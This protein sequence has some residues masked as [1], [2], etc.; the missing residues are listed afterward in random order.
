MK[1]TSLNKLLSF[2]RV[3][4]TMLNTNKIFLLLILMFFTSNITIGQENQ[5][6]RYNKGYSSE[7]VE[8]FSSFQK[9]LL[10]REKILWTRH[11]EVIKKSLSESQK[12]IIKDSSLS[13][14][15][16]RQKIILSLD[17]TQKKILKKFEQRIDTIR[18]KFKKSLTEN[19]KKMIRKKKRKSKKND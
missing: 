18:L 10:K 2:I 17:D 3:K 19:Q 12:K 5:K 1:Y 15:D 9:D 4:Q 7:L 6:I 13:R 14:R 11:H 16:A 8:S